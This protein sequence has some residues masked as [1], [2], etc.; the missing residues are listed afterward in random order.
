MIGACD[1]C[2][3]RRSLSTRNRSEACLCFICER[4]WS[5]G[6]VWDAKQGRYARPAEPDP[7]PSPEELSALAREA[8]ED[9]ASNTAFWG[10]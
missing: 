1:G 4:E 5:R 7:S 9:E 8:E 10:L 3:K 6:R 2:G